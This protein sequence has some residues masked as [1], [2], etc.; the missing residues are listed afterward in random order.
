MSAAKRSGSSAE[1]EKNGGGKQSGCEVEL[2]S[3][4]LKNY[5][6]FNDE[7]KPMH[8]SKQFKCLP[9]RTRVARGS[10]SHSFHI[11]GMAANLTSQS[12]AEQANVA[13]KT[14]KQGFYDV[15]R[16]DPGKNLRV[17]ANWK[18]DLNTTCEIEPSDDRMCMNAVNSLGS[19]CRNNQYY[20]L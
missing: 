2:A 3:S 20:F 19:G 1:N 13:K 11:Q 12:D 4:N 17:S 5:V 14:F 7:T 8:D 16:C 18:S 9:V 6:I 15:N 10:G